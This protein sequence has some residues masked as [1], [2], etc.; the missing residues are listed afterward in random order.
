MSKWNGSHVM[1]EFEK[2][3]AEKGLISFEL[4]PKNK[5]MVGNPSKSPVGPTREK[6]TDEYGVTKEEGKDLIEKAHKKTVEIAKALGEGAVVENL[7]EQQEKDL[8]VALKTPSG[9]LIGVHAEMVRNLVK[10]A[11]KLDEEGKVEASKKVDKIIEKFAFPFLAIGIGAAILAGMGGAANMGMFSSRRENLATDVKDLIESL[12]TA[13]TSKWYSATSSP[14]ASKAIELLTPYLSKV[15]EINFA[16]ESGIE[17]SIAIIKEFGTVINT[18]KPYITR[19]EL[20]LG[21]S[22]WYWVGA[23]RP[24]RIKAHFEDVVKDYN[25][26]RENL[27]AASQKGQ[28]VISEQKTETT[29]PAGKLKSLLR[30]LKLLGQ[31]A[32]DQMANDQLDAETVKATEKLEEILTKDVSEILEKPIEVKIIENGKIVMEIPKVEQIINLVE[33]AKGKI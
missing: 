17:K 32:D 30:K 12:E 18:I 33:K 15:Q 7:L 23:D 20:E 11:N 16:D 9:A 28:E 13:T 5:D 27:A 25:F 21:E 22:R 26:L 6:K 19:I 24:T 8:Y 3:A 1:E 10:L 2:I 29:S 4:N 31:D 14:S